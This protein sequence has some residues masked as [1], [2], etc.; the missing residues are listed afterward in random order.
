MLEGQEEVLVSSSAR[1]SIDET[2]TDPKCVTF[3]E[4]VLRDL[5][6]NHAPREFDR[7]RY[8]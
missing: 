8:P 1:A 3:C 2:E 5:C 6:R 4:L 7:V